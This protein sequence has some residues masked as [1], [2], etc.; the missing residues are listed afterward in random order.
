MQNISAEFSFYSKKKNR[1]GL[2]YICID[3]VTSKTYI[4]LFIVIN[5]LKS[6][7]WDKI[8]IEN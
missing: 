5:L 3:S 8:K 7:T 4:R 1:L 2:K 6:N